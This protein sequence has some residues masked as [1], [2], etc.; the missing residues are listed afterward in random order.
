MKDDLPVVIL[1]GGKGT[2]MWPLTSEIPKTLIEIGGKAV[3]WHL[4]KKYASE[5]HTNFI[6]CLG[7]M[8]NRI[9]QYF[10][11]NKEPGWKISFVNTGLDT[12]KSERIK[13]VKGLIKTENFFLSYGDDLS[14]V[15]VNKVL[16]FH[17]RKKKIITLTAIPL[18][19]QFGVLE[20]NDKDE[21]YSFSEKPRIPNYWVNGGFFVCS[22]KI[23]D[24]LTEGELED[25]VLKKLASK[26]Q[27]AAYKFDGFWKCMNTSKDAVEFNNIFNS[28]KI[29]WL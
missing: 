9:E 18:Y 29:P 23:F 22:N 25:E 13:K 7:H 27:V 3:L 1:C 28:G 2:R 20:I 26:K 12:K 11:K 24:Y 16:E 21:V 8:A 14:A 6:L 19:S 17:I 10:E 4:M 5:G 15:K